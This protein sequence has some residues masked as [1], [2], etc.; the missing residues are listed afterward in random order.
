MNQHENSVTPPR[1]A[2]GFGQVAVSTVIV[3]AIIGTFW[4]MI[5]LNRFFMLVFAAIVLGAVF[6]AIASRIGRVTGLGRTFSLILSVIGLFAVFIGSFILFGTQLANEFDTIKQTV[7][8]ALQ[9]IE[10][11]LNNYGMGERARELAK[12]GGEDVSRLLTQAGG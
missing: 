5:E 1:Q 4:L 8:A 12:V 3:V 11:F 7:P 2:F 10:N 6:D 9:G